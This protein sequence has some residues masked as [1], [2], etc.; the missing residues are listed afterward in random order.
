MIR[1]LATLKARSRRPWMLQHPNS[2]YVGR[3]ESPTFGTVVIEERDGHLF[4]SI[5][6]LRSL[7]EAFTE[8]ETARVEMVPG[9]GEVFRFQFGADGV[10][11]SLRWSNDVFVRVR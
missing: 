7:L 1:S 9:S 10:V 8:P 6:R 5:G 11:E 3:Y 4:A 2:A